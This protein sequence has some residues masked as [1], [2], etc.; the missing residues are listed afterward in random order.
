MASAAKLAQ[1]G[2]S[3]HFGQHQ[4][5]N[6]QI[7]LPLVKHLEACFTRMGNHY[8]MAI[9]LQALGKRGRQF[10]FVLPVCIRPQ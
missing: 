4:I 9:L 2:E 5:E 10:A 7:R 6:Q 8:C 3:V 1:Y